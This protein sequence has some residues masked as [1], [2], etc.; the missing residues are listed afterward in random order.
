MPRPEHAFDACQ[1]QMWFEKFPMETV[2][3]VT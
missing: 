1:G 2:I 3:P